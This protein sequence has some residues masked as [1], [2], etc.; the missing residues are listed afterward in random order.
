MSDELDLS[1]RFGSLIFGLV[2]SPLQGTLILSKTLPPLR[3]FRKVPLTLSA[4]LAGPRAL[5]A[6]TA[7]HAAASQTQPLHLSLSLGSPNS[8]PP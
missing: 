5:G 7:S 3:P 6:H 8:L 1:L 2:P 4:P